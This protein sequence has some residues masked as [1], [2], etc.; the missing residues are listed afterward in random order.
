MFRDMRRRKQAL[1]EDEIARILAEQKRGV[2]S[3]HGEDGYPYGIPVNFLYDKADGCI[4]LHGAKAG[5]KI[6]AIAADAR[7]CFTTFDDGELDADGWSYHVKSIVAFGT[8][9]LVDDGQLAMEKA[10]EL[11]R[12]YFPSEEYV[13]EEMRKASSR[14]QMIAI[15]IDHV[16]GK[17]VHEQ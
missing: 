6:D 12:K 1:P 4:Y 17:S 7:V 16:T 2:L 14:V 9:K 13:E 8:A 10:R 11:G 5:H 3:V 15:A